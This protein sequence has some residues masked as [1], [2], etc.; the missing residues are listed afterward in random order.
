MASISDILKGKAARDEARGALDALYT[1]GEQISEQMRE[2]DMEAE[3]LRAQAKTETDALR[4]ETEEHLTSVVEQYSG[5]FSSFES[6]S[7]HVSA[8][9]R[10]MDVSVTQLP[11][12]FNHLREG[13][14]AVLD[15]AKE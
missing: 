12:S 10:K 2:K 3:S 5:L 4:Q 1:E 6:I 13:L 7:A 15:K 14:Q 11:L 8:E 9:L